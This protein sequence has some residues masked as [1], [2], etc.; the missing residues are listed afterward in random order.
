MFNTLINA[1]RNKKWEDG[2]KE[3]KE[4]KEEME[5]PGLREDG[6]VWMAG[7][8]REREREDKIT[9]RGWR[10][11]KRRRNGVKDMEERI[12]RR[13]SGGKVGREGRRKDGVRK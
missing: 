3:V 1:S 9:P 6:A 5:E 7:M 10:S 8:E 2:G 12:G 4:N 11:E 13:N